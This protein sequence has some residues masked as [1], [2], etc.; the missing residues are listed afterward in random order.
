[1]RRHN[2]S[3]VGTFG[4]PRGEG[5]EKKEQYENAAYPRGVVASVKAPSTA[6]LGIFSIPI[7]EERKRYIVRSDVEYAHMVV[8]SV[9]DIHPDFVII[10]WSGM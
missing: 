10:R 4:V 2:P 1:M 5:V 7:E 9:L 6:P 8:H 3:C